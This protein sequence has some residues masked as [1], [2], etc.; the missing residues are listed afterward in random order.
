MRRWLVYKVSDECCRTA[1]ILCTEVRAHYIVLRHLHWLQ[2]SQR[3]E[4]KLTV[5]LDLI[6]LHVAAWPYT[7]R[8]RCCAADLR[9]RQRLR[10]VSSSAL[11]AGVFFRRV[12]SRQRSRLRHRRCRCSLL[13]QFA[14][15][16]H[17]FD[18]TVPL[19]ATTETLLF[20]RIITD[21][22]VWL[23]LRDTVMHVSSALKISI[24]TYGTL[25]I[26]I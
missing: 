20:I 19:E 7:A 3:I 8:K 4:F 26:F 23:F 22:W 11:D 12:V 24:L 18:V 17:F 25:M 9:S 2:A 1:H 21:C 5:Q 14:A 15:R 13:K 16:C 6:S 10:A